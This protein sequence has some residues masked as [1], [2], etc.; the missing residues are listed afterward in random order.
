MRT[1]IDQLRL[2]FG[3]FWRASSPTLQELGITAGNALESHEAMVEQQINS[4]QQRQQAALDRDSL[5]GCLNGYDTGLTIMRDGVPH[6]IVCGDSYEISLANVGE[7][8]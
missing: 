3:M 5:I 8:K 7:R 4:A 6:R 2:R 1:L